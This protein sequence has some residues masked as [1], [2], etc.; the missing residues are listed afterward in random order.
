MFD[1]KFFT[2]FQFPLKY[3]LKE[4]QTTGIT[5]YVGVISTTWASLIYIFH[6][7]GEFSPSDT[8]T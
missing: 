7:D 6:E 5:Y 2:S 1:S 4:E 8:I 3:Q